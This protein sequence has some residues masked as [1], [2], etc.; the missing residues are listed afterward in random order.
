MTISLLLTAIITIIE[1][2]FAANISSY[3]QSFSDQL[4]SLMCNALKVGG[5]KFNN[6]IYV[7]QDF[8]NSFSD[9]FRR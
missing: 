3:A 8:I 5:S 4:K 9:Y 6:Q 7:V 1:H 2:T